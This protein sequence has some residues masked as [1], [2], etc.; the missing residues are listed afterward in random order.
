MNPRSVVRRPSEATDSNAPMIVI[1][2]M[3]LLPDINGVC[4]NGG[5]FVMISNPTKT[6][7]VKIVSSG[8]NASILVL[9][10]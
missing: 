1:P 3:A 7:N 9:N 8:K 6:A 10:R 2:E 5:T 4:S